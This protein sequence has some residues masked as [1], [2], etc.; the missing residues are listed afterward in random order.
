M[1]IE[2][3]LERIKNIHSN[4]EKDIEE[5]IE[6]SNPNI[7]LFKRIPGEI[8]YYPYN[9]T[10]LDYSL[11]VINDNYKEIREKIEFQALERENKNNL[12]SEF[13]R[14]NNYFRKIKIKT[15]GKINIDN[16]ILIFQLSNNKLKPLNENSKLN[17][18]NIYELMSNTPNTNK[19][20]WK[21]LNID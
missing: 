1:N 10:A 21:K 19:N 15:K 7:A 12:L 17:L 4:I 2:K 11:N 16:T 20:L 8:Y 14:L 3:Q 18:F 6:S 13:N 9:Q 5:N